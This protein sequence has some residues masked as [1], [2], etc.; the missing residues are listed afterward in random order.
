ME[1]LHDPLI[2]TAVVL[3]LV[4]VALYYDCMGEALNTYIGAPERAPFV[5]PLV[6]DHFC[7]GEGVFESVAKV[8]L[9]HLVLAG[10]VSVGIEYTVTVEAVGFEAGVWT[11]VNMVTV[12]TGARG[13]ACDT[14]IFSCIVLA[15]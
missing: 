14:S 2:L 3:V 5:H 11:Y 8:V 1:Q 6:E 10:D 7:I 4:F 15:E 9:L 12:L 13:S